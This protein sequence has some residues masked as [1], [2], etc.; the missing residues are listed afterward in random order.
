MHQ[1]RL[2]FCCTKQIVHRR[3]NIVKRSISEINQSYNINH[4]N[5]KKHFLKIKFRENEKSY[6]ISKTSGSLQ[7]SSG[8]KFFLITVLLL[9]ILSV[10]PGQ[11][12]ARIIVGVSGTTIQLINT[13]TLLPVSTS[14][15]TMPPYTGF[16][17][18]SVT[19]NPINGKYYIDLN[20]GLFDGHRLATVNPN[21]RD[22]FDI[23]PLVLGMGMY[24]AEAVSL[25]CNTSTGVLYAIGNCGPVCMQNGFF[26]VDI[27][28]GVGT[29]I[30]LQNSDH[31][32]FNSIAHNYDENMIYHWWEYGLQKFNPITFAYAVVPLSGAPIGIVTVHYTLEGDCFL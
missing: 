11:I 26:S 30:F 6:E 31:P 28:T 32:S 4:K 8:A 20:F 23:G 14:T 10:L 17:A 27:N 22:C 24:T 12:K 18:E 5:I 25:T 15:L 13:T 16:S 9:I 21:T 29:Q 1:L 19:F 7:T 2:V 3:Q